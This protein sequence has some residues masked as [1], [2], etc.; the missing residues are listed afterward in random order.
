MSAGKTFD[1]MELA[2]FVEDDAE[3]VTAPPIRKRKGNGNSGG[4]KA[5]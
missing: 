1:Y 4:P 2:L 5:S 3:T